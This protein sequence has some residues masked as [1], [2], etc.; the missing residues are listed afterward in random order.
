MEDAFA[1]DV[2][3][4]AQGRKPAQ[5]RYEIKAW[6]RDNN[7][8][9]VDN[10]KI[11]LEEGFAFIA[12]LGDCSLDSLSVPKEMWTKIGI[13][14]DTID[15]RELE[16][17]CRYLKMA[18]TS[19]DQRRERLL[20]RIDVAFNE[21]CCSGKSSTNKAQL[22]TF[23]FC[24]QL[25]NITQL[26]LQQHDVAISTSLALAADRDNT[27]MMGIALLSAIFL[28]ATSIAVC[29][30]TFSNSSILS[31]LTICCVSDNIWHGGILHRR[32]RHIHCL[33]HLDA[34]LE[35]DGPDNRGDVGILVLVELLGPGQVQVSSLAAEGV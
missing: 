17:F 7:K 18:V 31:S 25:F 33:T 9:L 20:K 29:P 15:E 6:Y 35:M 14:R 12:A 13:K 1:E 34:L 3:S 5:E 27:V 24:K 11:L 23:L 19:F 4:L 26:L 16:S 22:T 28:P 10:H 8:K 30:Y 21:V 2:K 32:W